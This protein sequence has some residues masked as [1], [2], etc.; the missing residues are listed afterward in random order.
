MKPG[1]EPREDLFSD[2]PEAWA[3]DHSCTAPELQD[4]DLFERQP[5]TSQD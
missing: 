4:S 1:A 3:L 5:T 2:T